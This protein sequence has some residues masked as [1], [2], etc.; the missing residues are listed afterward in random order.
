MKPTYDWLAQRHV[1]RN[2]LVHVQ[3]NMIWLRTSVVE[4]L[5]SKHLHK[6]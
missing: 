5:I 4:G 2:A 6:N 3:Q 1:G